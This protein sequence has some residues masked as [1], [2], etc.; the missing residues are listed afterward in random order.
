MWE[1]LTLHT[2]VTPAKYDPATPH[3][4]AKEINFFNTDRFHSGAAFYEDLIHARTI[5]R[6]TGVRNWAIDGT[7]GFIINALARHRVRMTY[8]DKEVSIS[9]VSC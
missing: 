6:G 2:Q 7:V 9:Y 4:Y 8:P 1:Y 3:Y 5:D